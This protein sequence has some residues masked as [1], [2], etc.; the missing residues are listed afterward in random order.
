MFISSEIL[1]DAAATKQHPRRTRLDRRITPCRVRSR[2]MDG[3]VSSHSPK[4]SRLVTNDQAHRS[5]SPTPP[6]AASIQMRRPCRRG[7]LYC[8][9]RSRP[10]D[11]LACRPRIV[12]KINP[13]VE[14]TRPPAPQRAAPGPVEHPRRGRRSLLRGR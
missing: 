9:R 7:V 2:A 12:R 14:H 1:G 4:R 11:H 10:E 6:T 3:K 8:L 13:P 5:S